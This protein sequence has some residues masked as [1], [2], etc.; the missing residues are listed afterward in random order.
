[1]NKSEAALTEEKKETEIETVETKS[2][3]DFNTAYTLEKLKDLITDNLS[4]TEII[5]CGKLRIED[6]VLNMTSFDDLFDSFRLSL[7]FWDR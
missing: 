5:I 2:K 1:L 3:I 7:M 6:K 4:R